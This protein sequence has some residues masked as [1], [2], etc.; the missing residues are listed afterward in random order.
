M[1]F[2]GQIRRKG[3]CLFYKRFAFFRIKAHRNKNN[4][5]TFVY[6]AKK[7][8]YKVRYGAEVWAFARALPQI[9]GYQS[10]TAKNTLH[11]LKEA[12]LCRK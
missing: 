7:V 10:F 1:D 11:I 2:S 4:T 12:D 3:G 5:H 8:R 6:V 9:I